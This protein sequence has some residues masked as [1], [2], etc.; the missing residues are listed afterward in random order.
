MVCTEAT[1]KALGP[2]THGSTFGGN[3]VAAAA[4]VVTVQLASDPRVLARNKELGD[5]FIAKGL[6]MKARHPA[7]VKDARGQGLL[8]GVELT[9]DAGPVVGRLRERGVLSNLAG[10]RTVRFAPP[11]LVTREELD[12]GLRVLEDAVVAMAPPA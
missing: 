10:E 8:L 12:E 3:P 9:Y 4:G 1:G 6:E 2:G 7:L 5:Y 11:F